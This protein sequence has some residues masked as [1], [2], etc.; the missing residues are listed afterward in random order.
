MKNRFDARFDKDLLPKI[1]EIPNLGSSKVFALN[2]TAFAPQ[3][4]ATAQR[5]VVEG[6]PFSVD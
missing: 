6:S 2:A 3:A 4:L 5:G 1:A